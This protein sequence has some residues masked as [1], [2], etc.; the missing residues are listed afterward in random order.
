MVFSSGYKRVLLYES[1]PIVK[2]VVAANVLSLTI[3]GFDSRS[4]GCLRT[5]QVGKVML[6]ME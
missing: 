1:G 2:L 5:C 3:F 4:V 6:S